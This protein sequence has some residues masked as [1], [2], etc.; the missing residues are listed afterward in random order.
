MQPCMNKKKKKK[1]P[2][3]SNGS[4]KRMIFMH[5][6]FSKAIYSQSL[7]AL[8]SLSIWVSKTCLNCV[9]KGRSYP[10]GQFYQ[11][12]LSMVLLK[13]LMI[14]MLSPSTMMFLYLVI[15]CS[16]MSLILRIASNSTRELSQC[17]SCFPIASLQLPTSSLIIALISVRW[18]GRWA[19][20][21][22]AWKHLGWGDTT[23]KDCTSQMPC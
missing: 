20:L 2:V 6:D 13:R 17:F 9:K 4:K 18:E 10:S 11:N 7:N 5:F 14:L 19:L 15:H 3:I 12:L 1:S 8:C 16:T 23:E 22:F 21:T